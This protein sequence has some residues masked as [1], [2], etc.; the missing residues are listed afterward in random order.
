MSIFPI[1]PVDSEPNTGTVA[2]PSQQKTTSSVLER[3]K[4]TDVSPMKSSQALKHSRDEG[5]NQADDQWE[6][7]PDCPLW[8]MEKLTLAETWWLV[9]QP[10]VNITQVGDTTWN[11]SPTHQG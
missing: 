7:D 9:L 8:P 5:E 6:T 1:N 11:K 2:T 4:T 10:T 3:R